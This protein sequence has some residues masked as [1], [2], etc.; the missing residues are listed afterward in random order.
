M[1]CSILGGADIIVPPGVRVESNGIAILGGF[2]KGPDHPTDP[3]A[4][5]IRINGLVMLGA[6]SIKERLPGESKREARRRL[7]AERMAKRLGG[8]SP[9]IED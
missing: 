8:V 9:G 6:V 4:P 3:D 1:L 7:K 2:G 5:T